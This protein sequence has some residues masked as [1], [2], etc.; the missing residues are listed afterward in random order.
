MVRVMLPFLRFWATTRC[1]SW[2]AS[3]TSDYRG[4][5]YVIGFTAGWSFGEQQRILKY[6]KFNIKFVT[7]NVSCAL[8]L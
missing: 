6:M 2:L 5:N 1:I 4:S 8:F 3:F 7:V